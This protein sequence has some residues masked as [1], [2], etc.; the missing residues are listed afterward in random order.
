M[1]QKNIVGRKKADP[2]EQSVSQAFLPVR[3]LV[4]LTYNSAQAKMSVP[5]KADFMLLYKDSLQFL[6]QSVKTFFST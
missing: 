5:L 3:A 6:L 2:L 4:L 1:I